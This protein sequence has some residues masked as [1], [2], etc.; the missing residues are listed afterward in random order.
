[1]RESTF[2][3]PSGT[4]KRRGAAMLKSDVSIG[5]PIV[6]DMQSK[7]TCVLRALCGWSPCGKT[8]TAE[9][10]EVKR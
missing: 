5:A 7:K 10:A 9:V 2:S 3:Q 8:L 1:M 6:E 4:V